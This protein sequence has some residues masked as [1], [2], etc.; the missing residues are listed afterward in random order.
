M[1]IA[2]NKSYPLII[3]RLPQTVACFEATEVAPSGYNKY[4]E[5]P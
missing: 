5:L 4:V 2:I 1:L 3:L